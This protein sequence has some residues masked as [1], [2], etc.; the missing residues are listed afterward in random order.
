MQHI[1]AIAPK[2]L[3][4]PHSQIKMLGSLYVADEAG[5]QGLEEEFRLLKELGC[6]RVEMW[7][8]EKVEEL[9]GQKAG[10]VRGIFFPGACSPFPFALCFSSLLFPLSS[11]LS[12]SLLPLPSSFSPFTHLP[13]LSYPL[14]VILLPHLFARQVTCMNLT[15][16]HRL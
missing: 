9:H 15:P 14:F 2:V 8:K 11:L 10:F 7:G 12:L 1:K 13:L 3:P 5:V 16:S 6:E 4:N